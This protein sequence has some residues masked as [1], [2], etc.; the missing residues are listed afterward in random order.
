MGKPHHLT[1]LWLW[2]QKNDFNTL[3]I[4]QNG[5]IFIMEWIRWKSLQVSDHLSPLFNFLL[6]S[7]HGCAPWHWI[8]VDSHECDGSSFMVN[9]G[10][11]SRFDSLYSFPRSEMWVNIW[12]NDSLPKANFFNWLLAHEKVLTSENLYK[13]GIAGLSHCSLY[14]STK[15]SSH[16]IFVNC[17]FSKE[18]WSLVLDSLQHIFIWHSATP[19]LFPRWSKRYQGTL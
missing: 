12:N 7:L 9:K 16:H 14:L 13:C 1:P 11:H 19:D 4:F 5:A 3:F 8:N 18:V 17:I 6:L 15:E 2:M 10:Y